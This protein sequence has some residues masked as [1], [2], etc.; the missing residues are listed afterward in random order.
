M[1][2]FITPILLTLMLSQSFTINAQHGVGSQWTSDLELPTPPSTTSVRGYLYNFIVVFSNGKRVVFLNSEDGPN[3]IY[4]TYSYDGINWSNPQ[5]FNPVSAIGMSSPKIIADQNDMLHIIWASQLP[6]GLYYTKM[7][8]A[9]NIIQDSVRISDNPDFGKFNGMYLTVDRK[10]RLHVMWH[11]GKTGIDVPE[12]YYSRSIDGGAT[13]SLKDS[14]SVPDGLPSAFPR[15]QFKAYSGDTLAIFWRDSTSSPVPNDWDINM[16]VSQDGGANWSYPPTA[17]L[18]NHNFQGDPDLVIAPDG[19]FHLFHHESNIAAPYWDMRLLYNYSDDLGVTWNPSPTNNDTV[20]NAQR[21]YLAE[22]SK[23][24]IQNNVLWTF[25]KEEDLL[26]LQG[27]D[28][29]AAYSKDNGVSWS[30]PEY[31]SD[32]NDT[33]IGFKTAS[34]LPNGG[35]GICYELPNYPSAGKLRVFYKERSPLA[36]SINSITDDN[37]ISIYPNPTTGHVKVQFGELKAQKIEVFNMNGQLVF[38][39][40]LSKNHTSTDLDFNSY[41]KGIYVL[42]LRSADSV[43]SKKIIKQ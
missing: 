4:Y 22:G 1:K 14:L 27:G 10:D 37:N 13:W 42:K 28:M 24:D 19:R 41:L 39:K 18:S 38:N 20:S 8:S 35:L 25:W 32:R 36:L 15:G 11:E 30:T 23:Y 21:S 31:V 34:L 9:L 43:L 5:A 17:V 2:K 26:G 16:V 12:I 33:T 3:S 6:K 7:D 40:Q 29:V